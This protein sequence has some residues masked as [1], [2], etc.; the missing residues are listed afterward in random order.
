MNETLKVG[1]GEFLIVTGLV[2]ETD[3]AEWNPNNHPAA[4]AYAEAAKSERR[5]LLGLPLK[6]VAVCQP[7][8]SVCSPNCSPGHNK[9]VV[10]Q[11]NPDG[12]VLIDPRR[13]YKT[14]CMAL[15]TRTVELDVPNRAYVESFWG[16]QPEP[17]FAPEIGS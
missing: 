5:Q 15:D 10:I 3:A 16:P 6:I 9:P 12:T 4:Q 8:V 2:D 17:A 11:L 14:A 13:M 7:F 1:P